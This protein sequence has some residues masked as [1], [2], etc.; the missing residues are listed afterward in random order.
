MRSRAV[1]KLIEKDGWVEVRQSGSHKQFRHPSRPGTI[2]VPHPKAA[3][4]T[5]TLKSI[6]KQSGVRLR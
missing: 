2:T 6:E 1:I 3:M 5:G 4:A